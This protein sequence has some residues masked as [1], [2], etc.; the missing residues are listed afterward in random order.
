MWCKK[1]ASMCTKC[2]TKP[3]SLDDDEDEDT[4]PTILNI[5]VNDEDEKKSQP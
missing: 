5:E 1:I 4:A 3:L 2:N